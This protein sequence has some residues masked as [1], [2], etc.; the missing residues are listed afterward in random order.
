MIR[1]VNPTGSRSPFSSGSC[2]GPRLAM[3]LIVTEPSPSE[4]HRVSV[5]PAMIQPIPEK[6]VRRKSRR[7]GSMMGFVFR[8][9]MGRRSGKNR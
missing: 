6:L 3:L 7:V 4:A 9:T 8:F 1:L 5:V 2:S